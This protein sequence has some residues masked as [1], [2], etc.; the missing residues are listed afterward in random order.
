VH[1]LEKRTDATLTWRFTPA[2]SLG[3]ILRDKRNRP[4]AA[5]WEETDLTLQL[6]CSPRF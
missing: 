6:A 4:A 5:P 2:W 3:L 1:Y